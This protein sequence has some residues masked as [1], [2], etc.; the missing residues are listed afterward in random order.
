MTDLERVKDAEG[1]VDDYREDFPDFSLP[2]GV[3]LNQPKRH[4]LDSV[5]KFYTSRNLIA[6]AA[7]WREIRKIEDPK[8]APA[9]GFVFTSLY[10]RVTKL[11]EYRFWGGSGNT[12]NFNVP[13]ISNETNV[14]VTFERK[15]KSIADH[16]LTTAAQYDGRS[17]VRTGSAT[18]L[19]F[20][21]DNSIDF[22]FT[23]PPFGAN[24]NYSEMNLLWESWLRSFTNAADEAIMNRAQS[25][26]IGDYEL[27]MRRT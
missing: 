9:V 1:L 24:I 3:N 10:Q 13:Q 19:S 18:D 27:L 25:K 6:C 2:D 16:F 14:F 11:S 4:G 21:P 5:E 8:L 7:I 22:I 20:L 26:G 23:D 15:A 12:A 17:V